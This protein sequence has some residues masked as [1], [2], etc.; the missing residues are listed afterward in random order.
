[1][2]KWYEVKMVDCCEEEHLVSVQAYDAE[3]AMEIADDNS[4]GWV[5]VSAK[6]SRWS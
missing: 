2:R 1:M 4:N 3:D 5:A 6:R